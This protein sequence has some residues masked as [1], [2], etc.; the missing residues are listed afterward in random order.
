MDDNREILLFDGVCNFCNAT[1]KFILRNDKA[2]RFTLGSIQSSPGQ[3]LIEKYH[4]PV[5]G[6]ETFVYLHDGQYLLRSDAI[7]QV[8]KNLG[9][10][11]KLTYIFKI[12]PRFIRDAVYNFI[13]RNR[14]RFF[15]KRESCMLPT[16]EQ[17]A[18]FLPS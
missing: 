8:M 3:E 5:K 6:L 16:P 14:Y 1:V 10:I 15:G 2:G 12:V 13:A 18:R 17:R 4:I 9:G 11:W 7:L